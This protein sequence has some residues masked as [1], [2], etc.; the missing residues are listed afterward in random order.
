M[1]AAERKLAMDSVIYP[2]TTRCCRGM[3]PNRLLTALLNDIVSQYNHLIAHGVR[4]TDQLLINSGCTNN[5]QEMAPREK[6]SEPQMIYTVFPPNDTLTDEVNTTDLCH[7]WGKFPFRQQFS[8][9]I[10]SGESQRTDKNR[11]CCWVLI[12]DQV[13]MNTPNVPSHIAIY[14]VNQ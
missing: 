2:N 11:G 3:N 6:R 5:N 13:Q 14:T 9:S 10:K 7:F 8:I 12:M 1:R 4:P